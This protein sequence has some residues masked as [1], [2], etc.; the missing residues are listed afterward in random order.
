MKIAVIGGLGYVGLVSGACLADLGNEVIC[1]GLEPEKIELLKKAK[2]PIYEPGL[3]DILERNIREGRLFFTLDNQEAVHASDIIFITVGTPSN[4][5]GSANLQYIK[6]AIK[7][8]AQ[9]LANDPHPRH[10]TI[11]NKSTVPVGT[12]DQVTAWVKEIYNGP[13]DVVSNPEFLREGTAVNDF[14][15]PDRIIIGTTTKQAKQVMN[16]LYGPQ[17]APIIQT[18]LK[19]A[20]MIK[21]A[22][23]AYL[24]TSISF[25]N[26]LT[27][28]CEKLGADITE[29][30]EGMR[31]DQRI[32]RQA[33]LDAGIG[34][35]GSCFPKDVKAL[36]QTGLDNQ[37]ELPILQAVEDINE[38]QKLSLMPKIDGLCPDL[39]NRK[40][41]VW[42]LAFKP[43]TDD[44]REAPSLVLIE[45]LQKR[46]AK[47]AIFD[48]VAEE[49]G[50]K[51][52][53]N[54]TFHA[55]PIEATIDACLLVIAT[56]W[57]V[58]EGFDLGELKTVM[59]KPN[60]ADGR[61]I[62]DPAKMK[63]LGFNYISVGR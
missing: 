8:V 29:V 41:A 50:R 16:E 32:G 38:Q 22:S 48:P 59:A 12:G 25:I 39:K 36:I 19:T 11:V 3:E 56:G 40:V 18:T 23:N 28:L 2:S 57:R 52:L 35:G 34:Y 54:V 1:T 30:A 62:Y 10:R 14:S 26:G 15:R 58:F 7:E 27:A 31:Y 46:G 44:I 49:N 37:L 45:E 6:Q 53:T 4:P 13:F 9:A 61:N 60:I 21:Y 55:K 17:N 43:D 20:E 42:G 63:K 5:D 24:A 51:I 47:V 33:F